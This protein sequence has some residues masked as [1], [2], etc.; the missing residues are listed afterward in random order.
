MQLIMRHYERLL[1]VI[2][3]GAVGRNGPIDE[4]FRIASDGPAGMTSCP[5]RFFF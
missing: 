5:G 1:H 4:H 3:T 2:W